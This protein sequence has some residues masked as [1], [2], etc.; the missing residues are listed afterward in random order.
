MCYPTKPK[1]PGPFLSK[2]EGYFPKGFRIDK[3]PAYKLTYPKTKPT[4]S[5]KL[6]TYTVKH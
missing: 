4:K 6:K 3:P 1:L 2:G 5:R